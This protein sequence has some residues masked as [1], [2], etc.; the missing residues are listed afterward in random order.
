MRL[1]IT[2]KHN[3]FLFYLMFLNEILTKPRHKKLLFIFILHIT[4][5]DIISLQEVEMEQFYSFF[6]HE[7]KRDGYEV[8][9]FLYKIIIWLG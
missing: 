6:L 2:G 8:S 5:A 9:S 1:D 3:L 4:S 7:L